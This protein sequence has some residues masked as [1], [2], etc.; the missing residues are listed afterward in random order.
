M[1]SSNVVATY[2]TLQNLSLNSIDLVEDTISEVPPQ[3]WDTEDGSTVSAQTKRYIKLYANESVYPYIQVVATTGTIVYVGVGVDLQTEDLLTFTPDLNAITLPPGVYNV[4]LDKVGKAFNYKAAEV[5]PVFTF[6]LASNTVSSSVP[7]Y[8]F[9]H[10]SYDRRYYIYSYTFEGSCPL[11]KEEVTGNEFRNGIIYAIY[12]YGTNQ[13]SAVLRLNPPFCNYGSSTTDYRDSSSDM[14][15][16]SLYMTNDPWGTPKLVAS[17]LGGLSAQGLFRLYAGGEFADSMGVTSG[18]YWS[19]G[20]VFEEVVEDILIFNNSSSSSLSKIPFSG[21]NIEVLKLLSGGD[22]FLTPGDSVT[23]VTWVSPTS[24][25]NPRS[26]PLQYNEVIASYFGKAKKTYAIVRA[27][28]IS[29]Y[30]KYGYGFDYDYE[31]KQFTPGYVFAS[32]LDGRAA[33]IAMNPPSNG[34]SIKGWSG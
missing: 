15:L 24:Y 12:S 2:T 18:W 29:L 13:G 11:K 10:I 32:M 7:S 33:T 31:E 21:V 25:I 28:Y 16:P 22:T 9:C 27:T 26:R 6:S 14:K 1:L 20:E 34:S 5:D 8:S 19:T 4:V 30:V 3:E 23:D 17:N